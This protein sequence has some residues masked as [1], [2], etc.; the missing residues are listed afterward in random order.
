MDSQTGK[1]LGIKNTD[2]ASEDLPPLGAFP[3][4]SKPVKALRKKRKDKADRLPNK[5]GRKAKN[6]SKTVVNH[7]TVNCGSECTAKVEFVAVAGEQ[8]PIGNQSEGKPSDGKISMSSSP[9]NDQR[10][11][12]LK[13]LQE[14]FGEI[15]TMFT[16]VLATLEQL[17]QHVRDEM[18]RFM[19]SMPE[20]N[21]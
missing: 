15:R 17:F 16:F 14:D 7:G 1:S 8:P 2:K 9:E 21:S 3:N 5:P 20:S 4:L 13:H 10:A 19:L 12:A 11:V 6:P 18:Q